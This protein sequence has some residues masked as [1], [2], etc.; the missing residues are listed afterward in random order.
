MAG[1]F[2]DR[3]MLMHY[4]GYGIGHKG[5]YASRV[6]SSNEAP[7]DEGDQE[8]DNSDQQDS[9]TANLRPTLDVN[10]RAAHAHAE[11]AV[12]DARIEEAVEDAGLE[13]VVNDAQDD[14][15]DDDTK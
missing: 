7:G 2:V 9:D 11:Q 10:Q 1:R 12:D 6:V 14:D 5:Y 15:G 13:E 8:M 3:D 4:L